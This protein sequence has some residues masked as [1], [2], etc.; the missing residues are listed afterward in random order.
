MSG[1]SSS[2]LSISLETHLVDALGPLIPLLPLSERAQLTPYVSSPNRPSSIPYGLLQSISQWTRSP[3]GSQALHSASLKPNDY[4]MIALLAGTKTSPGSKLPPY[5]PPKEA[6][7]IA[8][9]SHKERKA[10]GAIVNGVFSVV[11]TGAAAWWGSK[12]TGWKN[13]WRVLF[14]FFAATSVA[15]AE[16]ILYIFWQQ[17]QNAPPKQKRRYVRIRKVEDDADDASAPLEESVVNG[18]RLRNSK[19]VRQDDE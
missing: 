8:R 18:L 6:D 11:G 14:A 4:S 13:E 15:L 5:R 3:M 17:R 10:I 12:H 7:E 16:V 2:Q 1:T 19:Q 9:E